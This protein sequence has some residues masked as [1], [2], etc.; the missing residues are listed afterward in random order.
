MQSVPLGECKNRKLA[1]RACFLGFTGS[2]FFIW[3]SVQNPGRVISSSDLI[4]GPWFT[5][6][7]NLLLHFTLFSKTSVEQ[8]QQKDL[9]FLF[10]SFP[11]W[12]VGVCLSVVYLFVCFDVGFLCC[13][14]GCFGTSSVNQAG[15]KPR[16]LPAC[17]FRV[18][19]LKVY[20]T[21]AWP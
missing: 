12:L 15:L 10:L 5:N 21:T 17:T 9:S 19:G 3:Q 14:P 11:F 8:L 20:T 4:V 2:V 6:S 7:Q 1:L 13:S 16:D 18:R